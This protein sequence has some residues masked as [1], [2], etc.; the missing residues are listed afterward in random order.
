MVEIKV[1][2]IGGHENVDVIAVEVKAG[3][4]VA[5]DDA[6]IT[7]ETDKATMDVPADTAGVVKEVKVKVGD[8]VSEGSVIVLVEAT[9]AAE[10]APAKETAPATPAQ[11]A[12]APST[13]GNVAKVEV[14]DIGGHENVDVIAVEV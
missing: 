4:T 6:L 7:L 5:V 3:D 13:G 12:P 11:A 10:A 9:G 14:P 8:K 2:D 1:P